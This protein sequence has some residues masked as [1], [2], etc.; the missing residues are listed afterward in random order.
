MQHWT[1][2]QN[3]HFTISSDGLKMAICSWIQFD[4]TRLFHGEFSR[5]PDW[6]E[7]STG[8]SLLQP[9]V[10]LPDWKKKSAVFV[11]LVLHQA[12]PRYRHMCLCVCSTVRFFFNRVEGKIQRT[13]A[14]RWG[15]PIWVCVQ[16]GRPPKLWFSFWFHLTSA[17][18]R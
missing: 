5:S 14:N 10:L 15:Y 17:P 6:V 7:Q 18:K 4:W 11:L 2:A 13:P 12:I 8:T 1:I 16:A 3:P 9:E